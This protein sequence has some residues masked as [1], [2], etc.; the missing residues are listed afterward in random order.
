MLYF[1]SN[2]ASDKGCIWNFK[3]VVSFDN[4][5]EDGVLSRYNSY[6][7]LQAQCLEYFYKESRKILQEKIRLFT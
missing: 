1:E 7:D 5:S 4:T 2:L 3:K 6:R